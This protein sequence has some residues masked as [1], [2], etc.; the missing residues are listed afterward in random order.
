MYVGGTDIKAL[1]HRSMGWSI[2][3]SMK[4]WQVLAIALVI[5][6]HPDRSVSVR[7]N[8]AAYRWTSTPAEE[9]GSPKWL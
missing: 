3:R 5:I 7:D 9:T 2:T 4:P 6:I 8:G 1:H